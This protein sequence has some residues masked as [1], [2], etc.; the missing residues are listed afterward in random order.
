MYLVIAIESG[1]TYYIDTQLN[2]HT[3][4]T[5]MCLYEDYEDANNV[6]MAYMEKYKTT[7]VEVVQD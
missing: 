1:I 2:K 7:N 5:Q 4:I 3:C 6:K